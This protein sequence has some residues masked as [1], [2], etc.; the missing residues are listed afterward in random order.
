[1]SEKEPIR[2]GIWGLGRAGF[3]M[4]TNELKKYGEE[5][6]VVAACDID[7]ERFEKLHEKFPEAATYTD[8][9]AFL[10]DA[11]VELVSVAVRSPQHVD[12]AIRALDKG[13]M[14]FLEKPIALT[15]LGTAKLAEAIKAHP[16]KL[17]FRHNRRFEL[18]FNQALDIMHSGILGDVFEIRMARHGF[19]FR[20]D[21]Q[22]IIDCGG[23]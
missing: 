9:E 7:A 1:M 23:G 3:G 4:H 6:T 16:G 19:G 20:E 14:V 11:N 8:G 13:K 22:A 21:W 10:N 5:F 18:L 15:T 17:F 2:V 12:Y